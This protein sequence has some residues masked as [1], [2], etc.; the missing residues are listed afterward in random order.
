MYYLVFSH[1]HITYYLALFLPLI[2]MGPLKFSQTHQTLLRFNVL[3][4]MVKVMALDSNKVKPIIVNPLAWL[5]C[6][7]HSSQSLFHFFLECL[8]L[9]KIS[10]IHII[11]FV[12]NECCYN[13]VVF[14]RKKCATTIIK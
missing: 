4:A 13:F 1:I 6:V 3:Q 14:L 7:I 12:E 10:M 9:E 11:S 8:K 5:W 2:A